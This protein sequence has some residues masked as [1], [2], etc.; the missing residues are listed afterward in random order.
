MLLVLC[1]FSYT[2]IAI[3]TLITLMAVLTMHYSLTLFILIAVF[4]VH[5]ILAFLTILTISLHK[6]HYC[7]CFVIHAYTF[8]WWVIAAISNLEVSARPA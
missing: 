7:Y 5:T 2:N 6:H 8:C 1:P 3:I 4:M